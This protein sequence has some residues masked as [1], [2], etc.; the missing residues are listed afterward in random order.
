MIDM[1]TGERVVV[2]IHDIYGPYIKISNY[3]DAGALEDA[4]DEQYYVLYWKVSPENPAA[5]EWCEYYFGGGADQKIIQAIMDEIH[6][7][8]SY[9]K[10]GDI[11]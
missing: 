5:D 3:Q 2:K 4:F 1:K 9:I 11:S 8:W 10:G 7:D 6:F